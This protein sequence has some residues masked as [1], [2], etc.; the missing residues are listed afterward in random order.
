MD[1]VLNSYLDSL[2]RE[3]E[4]L[5]SIGALPAPQVAEDGEEVNW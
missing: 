2:D 3:I 1:Q 4:F 5:E